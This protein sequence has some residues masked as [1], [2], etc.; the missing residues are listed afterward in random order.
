MFSLQQ[1]MAGV[2]YCIPVSFALRTRTQILQ[3]WSFNRYSD[4]MPLTSTGCFVHAHPGMPENYH[5][6]M[7]NQDTPI[8]I[9]DIC[10]HWQAL[11]VLAARY[12]YLFMWGLIFPM[13]FQV[14][15]SSK[16]WSLIG[17]CCAII[18]YSKLD[19]HSYLVEYSCQT[20]CLDAPRY[21]KT[22]VQ[23]PYPIA[24]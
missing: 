8:S 15:K 3:W 12:S 22:V 24:V 19:K 13:V 9:A 21:P 7:G 17:K 4:G 11:M 23:E 1:L 20:Q 14:N 5:S 16:N 2:L 18:G 6:C 10:Q